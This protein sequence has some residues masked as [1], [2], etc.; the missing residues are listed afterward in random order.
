MSH[1]YNGDV[2]IFRCPVIIGRKRLDKLALLFEMVRQ[3]TNIWLIGNGSNKIHFIYSLDLIDAINLSLDLRGKNLFNIGSDN[4][5]SISYIF[6]KLLNH[7]NSNKKIKNFPTFFGL[8]ILK[9]LNILNFVNLGPYHQRMLVSNCV[10]NTDRI[11]K[12][13]N[14]FPKYT[15]EQMLI[16][17]Y[18]YY[19]ATLENLKENSSSKKLPNLTLIKILNFFN[20]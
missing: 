2:T 19:L 15:N 14:W 1:T 20:L 4:V 18:D 13:I 8:L 16:E 7:A 12:K 9:L 6:Q 5:K 11:K 3:K 17:C 10:L